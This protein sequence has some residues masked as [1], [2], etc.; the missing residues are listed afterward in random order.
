MVPDHSHDPSGEFSPR[1]RIP[2]GFDLNSGSNIDPAFL[3]LLFT[4][5]PEEE[6]QPTRIADTFYDRFTTLY[7][8][9]TAKLSPEERACFEEFSDKLMS[10]VALTCVNGVHP[11]KVKMSKPLELNDGELVSVIDIND[12][13]TRAFMIPDLDFLTKNYEQP[14]EPEV[15]ESGTAKLLHRMIRTDDPLSPFRHEIEVLVD[16]DAAFSVL[17]NMYEGFGNDPELDYVEPDDEL[18]VSPVAAG[19]YSYMCRKLEEALD[20]R[21]FR[22]LGFDRETFALFRNEGHFELFDLDC[23][24][25]ETAVSLTAIISMPDEDGGLHAEP[26]LHSVTF[27]VSTDCIGSIR[28]DEVDSSLLGPVEMFYP[29]DDELL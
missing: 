26:N 2:Q 6:N 9:K 5:M 19:V 14:Y 1:N 3:Q 23:S 29:S 16:T 17:G 24:V 27:H 11:A 25:E 7:S 22:L 8:P 21:V 10:L 28:L 12:G 15:I 4:E 18:G 20:N 13:K